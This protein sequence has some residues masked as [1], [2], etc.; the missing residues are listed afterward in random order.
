MG[1]A[2]RGKVERSCET[3]PVP[4]TTAVQYWF[5][6]G[7][8]SPRGLCP[9]AAELHLIREQDTS[10][11][12]FSSPAMMTQGPH[13]FPTVCTTKTSPAPSREVILTRAPAGNHFPQLGYNAGCQ[14]STQVIYCQKSV[15]CLF[16]VLLS[17]IFF[18]FSVP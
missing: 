7:V 14:L 18:P 16:L 8:R 10:L 3:K 13:T 6:K 9:L 12:I 15:V 2:R 4:F 1:G 11:E 5:R 17:S